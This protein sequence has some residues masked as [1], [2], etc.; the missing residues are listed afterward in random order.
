MTLVHTGSHMEIHHHASTE[1]LEQILRHGPGDEEALKSDCLVFIDNMN[2]CNPRRT[3]WDMRELG[4]VISPALEEWIDENIN[5]K[6][7]EFGIEREAF[8]LAASNAAESAVEETMEKAYGAQLKTAYFTG[9][10]EA[11]A[12]LES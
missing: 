5:A 6:E 8:V 9:R 3:L 2:N 7:V 4:L 10:E 11:M 1:I 12:W